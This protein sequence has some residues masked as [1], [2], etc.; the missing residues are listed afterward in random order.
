[1]GFYYYIVYIKFLPYLLKFLRNKISVL[2]GKSMGRDFW[3]N[4]KY[5]DL[6]EHWSIWGHYR[7]GRLSHSSLH[8]RTLGGSGTRRA[9][10]AAGRHACG[11]GYN[12]CR[13]RSP[14]TKSMSA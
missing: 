14:D 5:H 8:Y 13:V 4:G 9:C 6:A 2:S 11:N 1:M 12:L 3:C 10:A 7:A